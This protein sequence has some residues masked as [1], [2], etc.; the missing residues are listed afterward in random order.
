MEFTDPL[1]KTLWFIAV[2]ATLIFAIQ[3]IMTFIG[4]DDS[5]SD[6]PELP[7]KK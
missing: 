2:P 4:E 1:L 7:V 3:S 5:P 6:T